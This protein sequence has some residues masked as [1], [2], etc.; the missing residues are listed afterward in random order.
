MIDIRSA[1]GVIFDLDGTLVESNLDFAEIRRAIGCPTGVD[2]LKYIAELPSLHTQSQAHQVVLQHELDDA[3][4]AAWLSGAKDFVEKLHAQDVP[5]AIVTRNCQAATQIKM[6]NNSIPID[7]VLTRED[8]PAK[9][10]PTALLMIAQRWQIPCEQLLYV[11]DYI[12]DEQAAA[13]ANMQFRYSPF[14][15]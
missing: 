3:Q 13:N 6:E 11:G 7:I 8:A 15:R 4:D 12:Y 5:M 2:V 14:G 9:P 1:Q 10:D